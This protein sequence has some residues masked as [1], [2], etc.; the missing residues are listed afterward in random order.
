MRADLPASTRKKIEAALERLIAALDALDPDP[1]LEE[2]DPAG[3]DVVDEPHDEED[4]AGAKDQPFDAE[5]NEDD[6][7]GRADIIAGQ[8]RAGRVVVL[9]EPHARIPELDSAALA[10]LLAERAAR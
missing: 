1:D 8:E 10:K 2:D 6:H 4:D 3:G 7:R 5:P 9:D